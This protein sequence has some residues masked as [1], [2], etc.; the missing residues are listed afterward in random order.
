MPAKSRP[1][2][3]LGDAIRAAR[4]ERG[5][6]QEAFAAG[7]G[8]DRAYYGASTSRPAVRPPTR[9]PDSSTDFAAD[10]QSGVAPRPFGSGR[11]VWFL[12]SHPQRQ[13]HEVKNQTREWSGGTG[14]ERRED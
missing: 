8:I 12:T 10:S 3:A 13:V 14:L 2:S 1:L 11:L 6:T 5:Y 4:V 9:V 7:A